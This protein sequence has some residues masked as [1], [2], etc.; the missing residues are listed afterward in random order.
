[1]DSTTGGDNRFYNNIFVGNGGPPASLSR[2]SA[3]PLRYGGYGPWVYDQREFPLSTGGNVY[4]AG[5][6]PCFQETGALNRSA[7]NPHVELLDEGVRGFLQLT[8][9]ADW[10][11]APT[12]LVNTALL[13]KAKVPGL[14]YE[15]AGGGPI[16]VDTD[17]FGKKRSPVAPSAGPFEDPGP[18]R[19]KLRLW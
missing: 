17:Y 16:S 8:L 18:G 7:E 1:M 19:L 12:R 5:A 6:R 13:G 9:G 11:T 4:F 15:A 2:T 14:G 10:G 3:D